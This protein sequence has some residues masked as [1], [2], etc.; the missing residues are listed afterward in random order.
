MNTDAEA[1][2]NSQASSSLEELALWSLSD[3]TINQSLIPASFMD[4]MRLSSILNTYYQRLKPLFSATIPYSR[5]A[6][7]TL[8]N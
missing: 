4:M 6:V 2:S 1:V 7:E 5:E 8:V 3:S